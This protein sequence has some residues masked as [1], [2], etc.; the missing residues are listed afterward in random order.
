MFLRAAASFQE[1]GVALGRARY[2]QV[3]DQVGPAGGGP[4]TAWSISL[5]VHGAPCPSGPGR[6]RTSG[7]PGWEGGSRSHLQSSTATTIE[8]STFSPAFDH[9]RLGTF[10]LEPGRFAVGRLEALPTTRVRAGVEMPA[11]LHRRRDGAFSERCDRCVVGDRGE[12]QIVQVE[13]PAGHVEQRRHDLQRDRPSGTRNLT[14]RSFH[15]SEVPL[16]AGVA[17][18]LEFSSPSLSLKSRMI[19]PSCQFSLPRFRSAYRSGTGTR[20]LCARA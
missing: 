7:R 14:V 6:G 9:S 3:E 13:R 19:R 2:R 12:R 16:N 8:R 5:R 15:P 4:S 11:D 1:R 20:T 17:G 18:R 10:T